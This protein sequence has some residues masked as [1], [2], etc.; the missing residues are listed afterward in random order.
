ME[1][2][3]YL[4]IQDSYWERACR[5]NLIYHPNI[6]LV[7]CGFHHGVLGASSDIT[8]SHIGYQIA[9]GVTAAMATL[10]VTTHPGGLREWGGKL[11][12]VS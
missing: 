7:N 9:D 2:V 12:F 6:G 5:T 1:I 10:D 4:P 8:R 11:L 3:I